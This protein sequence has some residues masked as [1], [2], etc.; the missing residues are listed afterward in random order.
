[1][2]KISL[3]GSVFAV[4]LSLSPI[5]LNAQM[6]D[7]YWAMA[8]L[9]RGSETPTLMQY[10]GE[11]ETA[12][13]GI[14]Y[15]RIVDDSY[16]CHYGEPYN[17]VKLQYGYRWVD[18]RM[19]IYDFDSQKETL[20]FDF[21]LSPGDHFTTLNGI[22]WTVEAVKDTLVNTS[23]CC[24]GE[25]VSK[26]LLTVKSS[27]GLLTDQWL[28]DFGSF[29][30]MFMMNDLEN[31]ICSQTLW[32]EYD[33]GE[34]LAREINAD[35]FYGHDTGWL[36]GSYD[37]PP[38]N[39]GYTNCYIED[40]NVVFE[41]VQYWWSHRDYSFYYR[42]G[43]DIYRV[44]MWEL[45]PHVDGGDLALMRDVITFKGL[46]TPASGQY[47]IHIN[48]NEYIVPGNIVTD[49]KEIVEGTQGD[50]HFYDL[51]G[52]RLKSKPTNGIYIKNGEKFYV[53]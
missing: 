39:E 43:D 10:H 42:N 24:L 23:F 41:D 16:M 48:N 3:I 34:Y 50:D 49:I 5:E 51:Q 15:H 18:K 4:L 19:Y 27:D 26:R 11:I 20:A 32:K 52:R 12:E 46:P 37:D 6:V 53:K 13:N 9:E 29:T 21:S 22:E 28:E 7:H 14:E 35:P 40:G 44:Y 30:D 33:Y 36:V 38:V 45:E 8:V 31:V 17:P 2:K 25:A 1:M 47:T